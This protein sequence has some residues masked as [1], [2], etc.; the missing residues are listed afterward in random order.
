[1]TAKEKV[2]YFNQL[3]PSSS[4]SNVNDIPAIEIDFHKRNAWLSETEEAFLRLFEGINI[5]AYEGGWGDNP[6][7]Y[8]D[9]LNTAS[10]GVGIFIFD[11]DEETEEQSKPITIPLTVL[12]YD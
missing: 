3:F 6:Y 5:F 8:T 9:N 10:C 12:N 7:I 2:F 4:I 11:D 1:M